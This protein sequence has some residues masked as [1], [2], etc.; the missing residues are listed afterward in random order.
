MNQC[1][2]C[3]EEKNGS[4]MEKTDSRR[5]W[6]SDGIGILSQ[7]LKSSD[8]NGSHKHLITF[9]SINRCCRN[10]LGNIQMNNIIKNIPKNTPRSIPRSIPKSIRRNN[11]RNNPR[12][13]P[14]NN[15][16]NTITIN[17]GRS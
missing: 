15:P 12:N 4:P 13:D 6:T 17:S 7:F 9:H 2:S 3:L 16:R 14:R 11:L 1:D 10:I 8:W 5:I